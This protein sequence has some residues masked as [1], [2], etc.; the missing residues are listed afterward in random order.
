MKLETA[1]F[2]LFWTSNSYCQINST[3][4]GE[5]SQNKELLKMEQSTVDTNIDESIDS[6]YKI[7]KSLPDGLYRGYWDLNKKIRQVE[8]SI[9]KGKVNGLF[10][11]WNSNGVLIT[12]GTYLNDSLWTFKTNFFLLGKK[13]FKVGTWRYYIL[14]NPTDSTLQGST[15]REYCYNI[16]YSSDNSYYEYWPYNNGKK[17]EERTFRKGQGLI[18]DIIYMKNG[19]KLSE[20]DLYGKKKVKQI[21]DTQGNLKR[22]EINDSLSY[23]ID[24]DVDTLDYRFFK[25]AQHEIVE[26]VSTILSHIPIE[27]RVFYRNGNLKQYTDYK[28]GIRLNYNDKGELLTIEHTD[29]LNSWK[30]MK[31]IKQKSK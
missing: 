8:F 10:R 6:L 7:R 2:I 15:Y 24:F 18:Q 1:I 12:I 17:W 14:H 9:D 26:D 27:E 31:K 30:I 28:N 19:N 16:P 20:Y 5:M 25:H 11:Y 23:N 4:N 21:W 3:L 22:L 29:N 13:T